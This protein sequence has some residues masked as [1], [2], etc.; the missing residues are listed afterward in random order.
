MLVRYL[1][2]F[3]VRSNQHQRDI[4]DT[5]ATSGLQKK[6]IHICDEAFGIIHRQHHHI[7][8]QLYTSALPPV[9]R[10]SF[11]GDCWLSTRNTN[12]TSRT[13]HICFNCGL[14][15]LFL[16]AYLT[17]STR[18]VTTEEKTVSCG[19]VRAYWTSILV[20]DYLN[21]ISRILYVQCRVRLQL[22]FVNIYVQTH[23]A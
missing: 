20:R 2:C 21:K 10:Q 22:E 12:Q 23:I 3:F 5:L 16:F 1:W 6:Y 18:A 11:W 13:Y 19:V 8:Q 14:L 17:I 4:I 7:V 15:L 9:I